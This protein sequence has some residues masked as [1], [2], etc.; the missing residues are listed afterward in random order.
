MNKNQ[1]IWLKMIKGKEN[2]AARSKLWPNKN[3]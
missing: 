2:Q 3:T 1:I